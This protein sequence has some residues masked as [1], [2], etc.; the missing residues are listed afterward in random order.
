[1]LTKIAT[2]ALAALIAGSASTAMAAGKRAHHVQRGDTVY[3]PYEV[4][5]YGDSV[6]GARAQAYY[7]YQGD[8][9]Q[10]YPGY[11]AINGW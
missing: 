8:G 9:S 4:P 5:Q 10:P 1:M 3:A 7:G 11:G 2:I 6:R